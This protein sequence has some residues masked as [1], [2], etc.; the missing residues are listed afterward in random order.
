MDAIPETKFDWDELR[1]AFNHLSPS[2]A[3]RLTQIVNQHDALVDALQ[4]E[5]EPVR[6]DRSARLRLF[7]TGH[8]GWERVM[9]ARC[10]STP[11]CASREYLE[12]LRNALLQWVA[13]TERAV[14]ERDGIDC[15]D[16]PA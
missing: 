10:G 15:R 8:Q 9:M 4:R 14:A 13:A 11:S 1:A 3:D 12:G 6:H 16:I 5:V 2:T 7:Q